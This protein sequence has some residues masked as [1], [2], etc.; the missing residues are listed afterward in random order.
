MI[1]TRFNIAYAIGVLRRS[2][3]DP[4]NEHIVALNRVFQYLNGTN[5]WQLRFG[6]AWEGES[7]LRWYVDLVYAG[8]LDNYKSTNGLAIT[9]GGAVNW[10]SRKQKL[11]AQSTTDA[12]YYVFAVGCMKLTQILHLLN[13]R[14]ILTIL[15]VFSDS[16]SLIASIKNRIYRGTA[17]A[18]IATKYYLA[19]DMAGDGEIDLSYVPTAEMLANCFT[20]QLPKPAFLKQSAAMRMIRIGFGNDLRIGI[21]NGLGNGHGNGIG[22]G[23]ANGNAVGK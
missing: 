5:D 3:H 4:S 7:A 15:H 8:C 10:Q 12:E 1:A 9:F 16:Q 21:G 11:T 23:N 18:H 2:N 14:G 20:N 22:T 17:D 13:N 6:G 19:A